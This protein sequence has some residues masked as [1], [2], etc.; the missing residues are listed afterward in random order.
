MIQLLVSG[1]LD[2]GLRDL[3]PDQQRA[4]VSDMAGLRFIDRATLAAVVA[5]FAA[6]LDS[7]G[8]H[9]PRDP[10]KVIARLDA[11]LAPEVLES[12]VADL[13]LDPPAGDAIWQDV[14]GQPDEGLVA[15]MAHESEEV[16]AVLLSKLPP[17]RAAGLLALMD[18]PRAEAIA[19]AFARTEEVTPDA[20]ARIGRALGLQSSNVPAPAFAGDSVARV[21]QILNAATSGLRRDLMDRLDAVDAPFAARVRAAVF[22][23]ENIPDRVDPRDVPK[24]LRGVE[25]A[26]VVAAIGG[27]GEAMAPVVDFILGAISSRLADQIRDEIAERGKIAPDEAEAA[28]AAVVASIRELE[29]AGEIML[30]V[31][32]EADET[33]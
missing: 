13:G 16:C 31:A 26:Q 6:E 3:P 20:V 30:V 11:A 17:P 9:F 22:S 33:E 25:N 4:L 29:E 32:G 24:V 12:L 7:I 19:A 14:A 10:A 28:M 2:P 15:I 23:F 27:A 8:L 1:G 21:G 18:K 5:E